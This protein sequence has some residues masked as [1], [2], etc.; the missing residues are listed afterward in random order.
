MPDFDH[1][2]IFWEVMLSNW[3]LIES[4]MRIEIFVILFSFPVLAYHLL[5]FYRS[6]LVLSTKFKDFIMAFMLLMI[7]LNSGMGGA[8]IYFQF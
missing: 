5:Y 2:I 8:F 4:R 7:I 3:Q 6:R 1:V